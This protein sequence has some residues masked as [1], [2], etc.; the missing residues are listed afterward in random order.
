[1]PIRDF[2]GTTQY[3]L[4]TI[5]DFD[6]NVQYTLNKVLD[7]NGTTH[8]T[9]FQKSITLTNLVL[10]TD[11]K[12]STW[13]DI[14]Y[15]VIGPSPLRYFTAVAN[16]QYYIRANLGCWAYWGASGAYAKAVIRLPPTYSN[17]GDIL[18]KSAYGRLDTT[19][20]AGHWLVTGD[21]KAWN[22]QLYGVRNGTSQGSMWTSNCM[23][24]D[25]TALPS[26]YKVNADYVWG[27][28]SAQFFRGS[29]TI[30]LA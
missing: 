11:E 27:A 13:Q 28:I 15:A 20:I 22:L 4:Q 19:T 25:V 6:W 2:N 24:V 1:M 21:G 14:G 30:T 7:F 8:Y 9:V 29:K 5:R 16:H 26:K 12:R 3:Q 23:I 10:E 18:E 17:G